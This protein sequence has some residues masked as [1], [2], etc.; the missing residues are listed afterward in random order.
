MNVRL[1]ESARRFPI[2]R[3]SESHP[4]L[5]LPLLRV[6]ACTVAVLAGAG[7]G[8]L[9]A[10]AQP[11]VGI[12]TPGTTPSTEPPRALGPAFGQRE[13]ESNCASC[14]GMNGRG[15]GPLTGFLTKSPPDLT[16]LAQRNGGVFPITRAYEVIEGGAVPAHGSREMPVWGQDY[17]IQAATYFMELPYDPEFYVRSRILALVEYLSRLQSR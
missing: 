13:F 5:G 17:R 3:T 2:T 10:F 6:A 14:H 9:P 16:Q 15:G 1:P 7:M 4:C 12:G 8:A 11:Q